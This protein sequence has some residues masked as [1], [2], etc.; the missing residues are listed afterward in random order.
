MSREVGIT[1]LNTVNLSV[2][3]KAVFRS[4]IT[5]TKEWIEKLMK[6]NQDA[7]IEGRLIVA[8]GYDPH[9]WIM[10][11]VLEGLANEFE[12][13]VTDENDIFAP[14][15]CLLEDVILPY[16][17]E[18]HLHDPRWAW[19]KRTIKQF[20]DLYMWALIYIDVY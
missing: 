12:I 20:F 4:N 19:D 1:A 15:G 8:C 10:R 3:G 9:N 13:I 11:A 17:R 7:P 6:Q 5:Y 18:W 2:D 16:W 14:P